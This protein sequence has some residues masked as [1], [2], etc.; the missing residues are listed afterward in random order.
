MQS[1]ST[2][3]KM[4]G[5]A[6]LFLCRNPGAVSGPTESSVINLAGGCPA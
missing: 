2:D 6:E 1:Q 3:I 4:Q 5:A